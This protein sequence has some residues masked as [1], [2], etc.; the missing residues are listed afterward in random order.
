MA[1]HDTPLAYAYV[2]LVSV[3]VKSAILLE[4]TA[5]GFGISAYDM[6]Y[7]IFLSILGFTL[8]AVFEGLVS[9]NALVA[10]P[11]K[12]VSTAFPLRQLEHN[13]Q[14][15]GRALLS[16]WDEVNFLWSPES[17]TDN[18]RYMSPNRDPCTPHPTR[19]CF[20]E[21]AKA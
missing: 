2:N 1:R 7:G 14:Q 20:G 15:Q 6:R 18:A 12:R 8:Y 9:L 3:I 16:S 19:T 21:S 11:M 10:S 17:N 5:V 13:M 4:A